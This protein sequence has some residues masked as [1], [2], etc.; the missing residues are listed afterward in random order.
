MPRLKSRQHFIPN[1][2][3]FYLPEL[4]WQAPRMASFQVICDSLQRVIEANPALAQKHGWPRTRPGVE[5]WVDLFN[6]TV[7]L[8]MGWNDYLLTEGGGD[9]IPKSRPPHQTLS[10]ENL[11]AAAVKAKELVAGA[12]T[13]TEWIDSGE[14]PVPPE[15]SLARAQTC[16]VCPLNQ[17]G[18]FTKWFTIPASE[19]IKAQISRMAERKLSTPSDDRLNLC[20]ACHC[21]LKL[22]VHI[23]IGWVIAKLSAEQKERLKGGKDCW[24]LREAGEAPHA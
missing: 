13:L 9:S 15:Q 8:R 12:K 16:A 18:D 19:L 7:C 22:K 14:P 6:A 24:I 21:P 4:K 10:L 17:A 20:I 3:Q 11:R 2:F 5:D 1:G 23:P